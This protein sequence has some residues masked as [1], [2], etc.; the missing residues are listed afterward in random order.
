MQHFSILTS[1]KSQLS[2]GLFDLH[3]DYLSLSV[4]EK[5]KNTS[6]AELKFS[7][8]DDTKAFCLLLVSAHLNVL[9]AIRTSYE[10]NLGVLWLLLNLLLC[11]AERSN[12]ALQ[13][14]LLLRHSG[15]ADWTKLFWLTLSQ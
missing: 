11:E 7:Q 2:L 9:S 6:F 5:K 15:A 3:A 1:F 10:L 13:K 8:H 4:E 12:P 14:S